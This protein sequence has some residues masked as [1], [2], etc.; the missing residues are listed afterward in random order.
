MRCLSVPGGNLPRHRA[1][2]PHRPAAPKRGVRDVLLAPVRLPRRA[3][4]EATEVVAAPSPL[5]DLAAARQ[6]LANG[7]YP[8]AATLAERATAAH[9]MLVEGYIVEGRALANHGDDDGAIV[10]LR[11]AVFLDSKA[12]HAHFLLA[13][14]LSRVGDP[15]GA[16]LS[17]AAAAD[18]LPMASPE[19]LAE[20][21]DGR[22]VS[23]LVDLCQ[24]LASAV[25]PHDEDGEPVSTQWRPRPLIRQGGGH[26]ERVHHLSYERAR[27]RLPLGRRS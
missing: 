18:T 21:L 12:A 11:K 2:A 16:A 17:F 20:L 9:P 26:R 23:D 14:T 27:P 4:A 7:R 13:T 15:G 1:N 5:D 6:A 19:T 22:A 3:P 25:Q 10:A 24:Q 8:E